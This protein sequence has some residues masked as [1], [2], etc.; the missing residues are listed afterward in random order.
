MLASY[1]DFPAAIPRLSRLALAVLLAAGTSE[2]ACGQSTGTR[3]TE[4][5]EEIIIEGVGN[6]NLAGVSNQNAAKSRVSITGDMLKNSASGQTFLDALNQ[7]P[8]LNFTNNDPYGNSGGN[9]RLRGFDGARVSLTFDG[10]PLNDTGNYAIYTNQMIDPELIKNLDVNLGTTDVDSPTASAIGGTINSTTR[11]PAEMTDGLLS[12]SGG[13]DNFQR[14]FGMLDTGAFG[15]WQTRAYLAA[16]YAQNDKFKGPG[17]MFKRQ[18]NARIYQALDNGNFISLSLHYNV[19][20]NNFYRNATQ[21]AWEQFGRLYDNNISCVRAGRTSGSKDDDNATL[22]AATTAL[23]ANDNIVN[24]GACTNYYNL[25]IN[26]SD[27]GNLRMSSLWNLSDKLRL[28]L[29]PSYQYVL[30]NGGGTTLVNENPGTGADRRVTGATALA[31]W[32]LNGDGDIL[33]SVRFYTP[34]TTN[35][36]RIGLNASLIWELSQSQVLRFAYAY[37]YGKHRQTGEYGLVDSAGNPENVFGGRDGLK[38]YTADGSYLRGRDRYSVAELNQFSIEYRTELLDDKLV[39]NLGLRAPYF[40]RQLNQY[41][42]SQNAST[43]VLCTTQ[44]PSTTLANGNVR[45]GTATTEFIPP[46]SGTAKFEKMLPNIGV[47]YVLTDTQTVYASYAGGLSAP[48]TDS[49]Y[50]VSRAANGSIARANPEPEQTDSVDLGW[51]LKSKG[52][53]A[54]AAYWQSHYKNRIVSSFDSDLGFSVDRNVG[55]VDLRGFDMQAGWAL[56]N[57]MTASAMASWNHSE[58]KDNLAIS[59]TTTLPVAGKQI[60][61]TPVWTYGMRLELAPIE[62]MTLG[63][64]GK[65]VDKR[66]TTDLN[67][68]AVGSYAVFH[69]NA[70]YEFP[71]SASGS[72]LRLQLNVYNLF[73]TQ[74]FGSISSTTGAVALPGFTPSQP[75]LA[76]GA[77]RT[78]SASMQLSF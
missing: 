61:E 73:D 11:L 17:E 76:L 74:F 24:P 50:A 38:V 25:R 70:A 47:T 66:F 78:V 41:C 43:N 77:P 37:D 49:L 67:D 55:S 2:F 53:L 5:M 54:S 15:P 23:P 18:L 72:M 7:V 45:F 40:T 32:D 34:N 29:D 27:T 3:A 31:G 28:T 52:L 59:A 65:W 63:L 14:Y 56:T 68:A 51:R 30:A 10:I 20:R 16:S 26:P 4:H 58:M 35:T 22:V 75:T 21:A 57:W 8:G 71:A 46:Y 60:V 19:N 69:L 64:E 33:D 42:Y 1:V 39:L 62:H 36:N 44:A 48:R 9:L 12:M 6:I 13:E